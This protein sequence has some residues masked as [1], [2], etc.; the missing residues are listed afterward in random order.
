MSESQQPNRRQYYRVQDQVGLEFRR[1]AQ[2]Q[3]IRDLFE[4][5]VTLGLHQELRRIDQDVRQQLAA[6]ADRDRNLAFLLKSLNYKLDT[7]ARIMAFEQKPLQPEQWHRVTL[8]EGGVAFTADEN[9]LKPGLEIGDK[10]AL[11]LT[12][13]PELQRIL[14]QGEVVEFADEA[15]QPQIHVAF[16]GLTDSDRQ[17]IA[18]HVL[19]VQ[20]RE[21]QEQ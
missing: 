4:D 21:R 3:E 9:T 17:A 1:I 6:L 10:L 12:L 8:S 5:Q 2:G 15:G 20:A 7:L 18:R 13:L 16:A 19:R 14:V 11:R